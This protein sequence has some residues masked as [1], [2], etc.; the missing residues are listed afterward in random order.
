MKDVAQQAKR[1]GVDVDPIQAFTDGVTAAALREQIL[2]TAA[3]RDQA[4]AVIS[5]HAMETSE[6][7]ATSDMLMEAVRKLCPQGGM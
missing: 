5:A 3:A 2:A 7:P 4:I 1:L 6:K